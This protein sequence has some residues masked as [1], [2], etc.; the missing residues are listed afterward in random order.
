MQISKAVVLLCIRILGSSEGAVVLWPSPR[1]PALGG[2][3][4]VIAT[5][6]VIK[7]FWFAFKS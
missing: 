6:P 4:H 1:S 5:I 3:R 7:R 2:R